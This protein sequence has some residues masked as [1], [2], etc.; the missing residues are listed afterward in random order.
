MI[1]PIFRVRVLPDKADEWRQKV[2]TVSI[3]WLRREDGLIAYYPG[4]PL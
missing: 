4:Q 1:V 2:E 3:P